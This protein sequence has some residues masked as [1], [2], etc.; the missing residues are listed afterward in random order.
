MS[1]D[2]ISP[3]D[4]QFEDILL[5][6]SPPHGV[7]TLAASWE[8]GKPSNNNTRAIS[9]SSSSSTSSNYDSSPVMPSKHTRQP[10]SSSSSAVG[11]HDDTDVTDHFTLDSVRSGWMSK[12]GRNNDKHWLKRYF[13]L[14]SISL[15]YSKDKEDDD[16]KSIPMHDY[17]I[18]PLDNDT[19]PNYCFRLFH[20]SKRSY[21]LQCDTK[22]EYTDWMN[23]LLG[24]IS[25][26]AFLNHSL[27]IENNSGPQPLTLY[28]DEQQHGRTSSPLVNHHHHHLAPMS[29]P[30]PVSSPT[31]KKPA[32]TTV[33][34]TEKS[35]GVK[36][37]KY[38]LVYAMLNAIR[39]TVGRVSA[40]PFLD[41]G[42]EEFNSSQSFNV[43]KNGGSSAVIPSSS[44]SY[45]FTDYAPK[46]FRKIRETFNLCAADYMISLTSQYT[47]S[48]IKT[49][50]KSAS[51]F[52]YT[53]DRKFLLKT[54]S[55][56]ECD[57]IRQMLPN[58]YLHVTQNPNTLLTKVF[59]LHKITT[60]KTKTTYFVVMENVF[61]DN[62]I[63]ETYDLKGST[64]GRK[65][66]GTTQVL[67]DLDFN[68]RIL[69]GPEK[70]SAL[71]H[72]IEVDLRVLLFILYFLSFTVCFNLF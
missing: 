21:T 17:K 36:D 34:S 58:Y 68:R 60:E 67:K 33:T 4:G 27:Q 55:T 69:L 20:P 2:Q 32:S 13:V 49:P 53:N 52:Y 62:V 40:L 24:V 65:S 1:S 30:S 23:T 71:L 56:S 8:S 38:E 43:S 35:V 14:S 3:S 66:D 50:G 15:D 37:Q 10:S 25:R 22:E 12:H 72:Q 42:L 31:P 45:D 41:I 57:N 6:P 18:E 47:L 61:S 64:V 26:L 44:F 11:F 46:V 5:S 59:G 51:F 9:L 29:K 48:E 16:F 28:D 19:H 70:K 63:H 7:A 54:I 39:F